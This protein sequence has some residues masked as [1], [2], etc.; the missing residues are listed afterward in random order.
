MAFTPRKGMTPER[1]DRSADALR[2]RKLGHTY[3][4]IG[5]ELGISK[6]RAYEDVQEAL[7]EITAEP[8]EEVRKMELE[9]LDGLLLRLNGEIGRIDAARDE[10][11]ID[12]KDA[13]GTVVKLAGQILS[14]NER[15]SRLLG[16]ETIKSEVSTDLL[17]AV[18]AAF[19]TLEDTPVEELADA[20]QDDE[21][22]GGGED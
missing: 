20:D 17:A 15:R 10:G 3:D 5:L 12:A 14:I 22:E 18:Q 19:A 16:L 1:R 4:E 6:T 21:D 8:A 9:R 2:L 13:A 11:L 7:R